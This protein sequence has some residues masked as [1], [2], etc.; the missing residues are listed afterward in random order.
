MHP[1]RSK[2][3][4]TAAIL[5]SSESTGSKSSRDTFLTLLDKVIMRRDNVNVFIILWSGSQR[6]LTDGSKKRRKSIL[7]G[8]RAER[9]VDWRHRVVTCSLGCDLGRFCFVDF[10]CVSIG[11]TSLFASL[12]RTY[13]HPRAPNPTMRWVA[14]SLPSCLCRCML[15]LTDLSPRQYSPV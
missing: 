9:S 12:R 3:P 5:P 2:M 11:S 10:G 15:T 14:G 4:S 8:G 1:K 6:R 13:S 7:S